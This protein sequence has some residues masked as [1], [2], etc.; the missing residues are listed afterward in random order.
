M[1]TY[2][3]R[4]ARPGPWRS[5]FDIQGHRGAKGHVAESTWPSFARA[6]ALGATTVEF[7]VRLT[8][9]AQ[10]VVWH[11]ATLARAQPSVAAEVRGAW[12]AQLPAEVVVATPISPTGDR[13]LRLVDL[14][15]RMRA[16]LPGTWANIEIKVD[17]NVP[18]AP[19]LREPLVTAVLEAIAS[20]GMADRAIVHSFDWAVLVQAAHEAPHLPRSALLESLTLAPGSPW[21][22]GLDPTSWSTPQEVVAAATQIGADA[23]C[24]NW[25]WPC[26]GNPVAPR[27]RLEEPF[28][29]AAHTAG[30]PVV[31][32]TV[33]ETAQLERLVGLG[34]DGLV[35]DYPDRVV[36]A[37]AGRAKPP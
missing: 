6:V 36:A 33:N 35:S 12:I 30:L 15:T 2:S 7:D 27:G 18:G 25:E 14:L 20:T 34:V 31:A 19:I 28:V 17:H 13:V 23:I 9:D 4:R 5:G 22:A 10:V 32:W 8:A 37:L 29:A 24:P 26:D 11:D 16:Q 21:L 1:T 3:A